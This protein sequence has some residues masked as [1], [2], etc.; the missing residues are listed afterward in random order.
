MLLEQSI[1]IRFGSQKDPDPPVLL[2][3]GGE[4]VVKCCSAAVDPVGRGGAV[5]F[6]QAAVWQVQHGAPLEGLQAGRG[7]EAGDGRR[8]FELRGEAEETRSYT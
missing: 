7:N 3:L 6:G 8:L 4:L 2:T 5:V 1:F